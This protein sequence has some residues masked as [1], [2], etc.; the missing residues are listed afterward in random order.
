MS[1]IFGNCTFDNESWN[2]STVHGNAWFYNGSTNNSTVT[3]DAFFD[4]SSNGYIVNGDATFDHGSANDQGGR[5]EGNAT[6]LNGSY[7]DVT[8][9]TPPPVI[10][11][12]ATFDL[13]SAV[14]Q[15]A[16]NAGV[17]Y[18]CAVLGAVIFKYEK[19]INGSSILGV[20]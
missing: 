1:P 19:G 2:Y 9:S 17:P 7:M 11:G 6:F 16:G 15:I 3:E 13:A 14:K 10:V 18:R 8:P 4:E 20:I 5:V 12:D